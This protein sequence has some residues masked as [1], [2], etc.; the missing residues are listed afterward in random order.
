M[1]KKAKSEEEKIEEW[2]KEQLKGQRLYAK[3][4]DI[5]PEIGRALAAAPSKKGGSGPNRPDIKM[6]TLDGIPVMIEVKGRDGEF[7]KEDDK[8]GIANTAKNGA[9]SYYNID[10]YAV[11]GAVHYA[12]AVLDHTESYREVLA[13]G[14]NGYKVCGR[15]HHEVRIYYMSVD[16]LF[17]PKLIYDGNDLSMLT[18]AYIDALRTAMHEASLTPEELEREKARF[19]N[20]IDKSL[21]DMNQ[22][23]RDVMNISVGYRVKLIAGMVMA[24]LGAGGVKPLRA[25]ELTGDVGQ[26]S[27][28]GAKI[29]AR[30]HDYLDEKQIPSDKVDTIVNELKPAFISSGLHEV[31]DGGESRLH[32]LYN[33]VRA[34]ILRFLTGEL[35]NIDFTGRL[36]NVMN[37]WV[38]IPDGD[39]NDV[40]LTPR[41]VTEMMA[42]MCRVNRDSYVWDFALGSGGFLISAMNQMIADAKAHIESPDELNRKIN[43]IKLNQLLGIEKLP[44]VYMLAVLNMI[45]MKDG[46]ANLIHE[47]SLTGFDGNYKFGPNAGKPFHADVFL[48]NPPYS[49]EGKGFIF[50]ERALGMM[51]HGMAAVLI[52]ESAGSGAG[53]PYTRRILEH[54][55]LVASIHMADIFLGKASVRTSVYVFRVGTPHDERQNVL[56][57]DMDEDGYARQN[58]KK[59]GQEVNLRDVDH[60]KERY[61]EVVDVVNFGT[62]H[63]RYYRDHCIEDHISLRGDDWTYAQHRRIDPTPTYDDFYRVVADYLSWRVSEVIK[64][65]D[66]LGKQ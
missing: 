32:T 51:D 27:N 10:H 6:M 39:K 66:G 46:S 35:H 20:D 28:D 40:V 12:R 23:M 9:V 14:V 13:V 17:L 33:E 29:L 58:R 30:V 8:G 64:G 16:N 38:D 50:V 34:N 62:S 41:Y 60:A 26:N 7:I 45:L 31:G 56:F 53:L 65:E 43:S 1:N 18:D 22:R 3:T 61:Q 59:S 42:R 54:N 57:I 24:G 11:N 19:E 25:E 48:L 36:F 2:A 4:E 63:L 15:Y 49:A 52:Q 47:N 5:N 21:K 37:D 55:T 44:D